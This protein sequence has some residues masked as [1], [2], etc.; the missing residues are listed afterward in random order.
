MG[1][2]DIAPLIFDLGIRW[3]SAVSFMPFRHTQGEEP[4]V[5]ENVLPLLGVEPWS[6]SP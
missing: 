6:S 4:R 5:R 1:S 3:R 2:R